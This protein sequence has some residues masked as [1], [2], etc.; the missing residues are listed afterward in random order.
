MIF[1]YSRGIFGILTIIRLVILNVLMKMHPLKKSSSWY[2]PVLKV[3]YS[4]ITELDFNS[5]KYFY[6]MIDNETSRAVLTYKLVLK[7]GGLDVIVQINEFHFEDKRKRNC[8]RLHSPR[9]FKRIK[10]AGFR[11]RK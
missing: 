5:F 3:F 10:R 1:Y 7:K 11:S 6:Y 4:I 2:L 8:V 9:Q